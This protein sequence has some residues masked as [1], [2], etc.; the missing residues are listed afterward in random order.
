[1]PEDDPLLRQMLAGGLMNNSPIVGCAIAALLILCAPDVLGKPR[2]ATGEDAEVT[3]DGLHRVDKSVMSVAWVKPD[4]DLTHYTKLMIVGA[5]ISYR[6]VDEN[7]QRSW[8]TRST[9]TEFPISEEGKERFRQEVSEAFAKESA[10]YER[11]EI[12]M[13]PGPD[14]LMLI[15]TVIDVVS[16]VTPADECPGRCDVYI[17]DVGEATLVVELRDSV[18]NEVLARAADRRA[19][20]ATYAVE[21]SAVTAWP[22]VARLAQTWARIIRNR[23]EEFN[24]VDDF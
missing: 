15:G 7:G 10:R 9:D 17:T 8:P 4:I 22:Q 3:F 5:G 6:A 2:L 11:Y 19:A 14:V 21:A 20:A 23:L 18:S 16:R 24:T 13:E 12:V 1:L